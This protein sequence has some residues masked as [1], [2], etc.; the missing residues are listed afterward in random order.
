MPDLVVIDEF[1]FVPFNKAGSEL[2]FQFC[3][4]RYERG[5]IIVTTNLEFDKWTEVHGD[6]QLTAALLDRLT[7]RSH[8]LNINGESYRFRESIS[9]QTKLRLFFIVKV[10][11]FL[12]G[13]WPYF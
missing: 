11:Y 8:I 5:S 7:H 12:T 4:A 1:G 2:L 9:K 3:S 13:K 6:E 10:A